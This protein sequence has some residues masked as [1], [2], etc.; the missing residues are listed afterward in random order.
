MVELFWAATYQPR[1]YAQF[2]IGMPV[3]NFQRCNGAAATT[4]ELE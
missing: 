1:R 3:W 2:T 4:L